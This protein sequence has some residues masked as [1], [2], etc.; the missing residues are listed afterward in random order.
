MGTSSQQQ[1]QQR[2]SI[3]SCR[4]GDSNHVHFQNLFTLTFGT[5]WVNTST[6]IELE[7]Y[8]HKLKRKTKKK[9]CKKKK[10]EYCVQGEEK[11]LRWIH[12]SI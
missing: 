11:N 10:K 9:N 7:V 3:L 12:L 6:V 8:L 4:E 5:R 2:G 1:Q